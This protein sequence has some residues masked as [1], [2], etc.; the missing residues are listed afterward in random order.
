[1]LTLTALNVFSSPG[2]GYETALDLSRRGA[3]VL[4]LC[5]SKDKGEAAV[6]NLKME[7][8]RTSDAGEVVLK[9]MDLSD[10]ESIRRCAKEILEEV[11][12]FS[13]SFLK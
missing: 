7:L 4:L 11:T 12:N 9:L 13:F 10:M 1:M 6:R 2:I 5:R 8:G 3:R